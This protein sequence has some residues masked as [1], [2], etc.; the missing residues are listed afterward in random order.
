VSEEPR[1]KPPEG[2]SLTGQTEVPREA[3]PRLSHLQGALQAF[4]QPCKLGATRLVR[5]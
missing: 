1:E 3:R 5:R 2:G 4:L